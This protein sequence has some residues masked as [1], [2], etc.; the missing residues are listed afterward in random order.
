[1]VSRAWQSLR[2][3]IRHWR[4]R[5]R[6]VEFWLRDDDAGRPQPALER[7]LDLTARWRI[8]LALAVIP[9]A[10]EARLIECLPT[11]A[12]VLQHG[13]D[14]VN[15]APDGEKKS[16]YPPEEPS[17]AA[18]ARLCA[19]RDRLR[20]LAGSRALGVFAPPWNRMR[21]D[22]I[23]QLAGCGFRGLSRFGPRPARAALPALVEINAHVDLIAWKGD[24][25]FVGVETA[26]RQA[27]AHLAAQREAVIATEPTGW[28]THHACH[29]T[30]TW[31]F[32]E[33]LFARLQ[34][35]PGVRWRCARELFTSAG[36][37]PAAR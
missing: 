4:E 25:G 28:L 34:D 30:A 31:N 5:G 20:E 22:L 26:L 6:V 37:L 13:A 16:E 29:D 14:H 27:V 24:R 7:L 2:S 33:E 1:M 9:Q 35:E 23:P 8:P 32:L 18:K 36:S 21:S 12:D 19:G 11:H 3:E 10:A 15:R 17:A